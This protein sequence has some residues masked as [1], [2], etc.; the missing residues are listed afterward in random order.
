MSR[1]TLAKEAAAGL[2]SALA[3]L[4]SRLRAHAGGIEVLGVSL[5][6]DVRLRFTG[7]CTGCPHKP[8]TMAATIRPVLLALEGLTRVEAEGARIS[9]EAAARLG[10]AM[11]GYRP[12]A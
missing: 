6:G 3:E 11:G 7:M 1:G 4:N 10:A 5:A 8:L 9:A 2:D 12:P